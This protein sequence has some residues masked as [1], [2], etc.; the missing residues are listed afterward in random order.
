MSNLCPDNVVPSNLN[1]LSIGSIIAKEKGVVRNSNGEGE[2][3]NRERITESERRRKRR[4]QTV[5]Q[6][7]DERILPILRIKEKEGEGMT[8]RD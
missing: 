3:R 4:A 6:Q 5:V 8:R 2:R 1:A 7:N